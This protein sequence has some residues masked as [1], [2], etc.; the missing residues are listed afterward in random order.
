MFNIELSWGHFG[1][2]EDVLKEENIA[3]YLALILVFYPDIRWEK[4]SHRLRRGYLDA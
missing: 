2:A 4:V 1:E 3:L